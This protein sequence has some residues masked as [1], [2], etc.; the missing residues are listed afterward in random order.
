M[1]K[2]GKEQDSA[3]WEKTD[4]LVE[5]VVSLSDSLPINALED[6]KIRLRHCVNSVQPNLKAG[7]NHPR[8]VEKIRYWIKANVCLEECRDYLNMVKAL[9][10]GETE[11]I[12]EKIDELTLML[13]NN[14][15]KFKNS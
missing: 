12:L 5:S 6:L 8:R 9:K 4:K 13:Q 15:P 10:Y 1:Y 11:A 2:T 7:L 3:L 14:F